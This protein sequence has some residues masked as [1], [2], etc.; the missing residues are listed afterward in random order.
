MINKILKA[1][2]LLRNGE[3]VAIPIETVYG[4][5][6]NA[7]NDKAV[8]QFFKLKIDLYLIL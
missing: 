6:A 1:A 5:A 8:A 4:L 2:R 7:F 3:V